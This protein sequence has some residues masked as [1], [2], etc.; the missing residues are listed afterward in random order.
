MSLADLRECNFLSV[1]IPSFYSTDVKDLLQPLPYYKL[2]SLTFASSCIISFLFV[3]LPLSIVP[4]FRSDVI[5]DICF[6]KDRGELKLLCF[7]WDLWD[8]Y[9]SYLSLSN[10]VK[11]DL[12]SGIIFFFY[13]TLLHIG[14][15]LSFREFLGSSLLAALSKLALILVILYRFEA[16]NPSLGVIYLVSLPP[17]YD[18]L[19]L[20]ALPSESLSSNRFSD[21]RFS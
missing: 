10:L 16:S 20:A 21:I 8:F 13:S 12:S 9:F 17:V 15:Y 18:T 4:P 6:F 14:L 11:A 19:L 7:L 1:V 2:Y 3:P 5:I